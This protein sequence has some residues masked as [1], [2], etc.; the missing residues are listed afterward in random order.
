MFREG[1]NK[2]LGP[3]F[4]ISYAIDVPEVLTTT[5]DTKL[6][7]LDE[8]ASKNLNI[9]RENKLSSLVLTLSLNDNMGY[10]YEDKDSDLSVIG[11]IIER[12][13]DA[14]HVLQRKQGESIGCY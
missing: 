1:L 10:L 12:F 9:L 13:A 4:S 5:T 3:E 14:G 2:V 11:S 7:I 6:I 8:E